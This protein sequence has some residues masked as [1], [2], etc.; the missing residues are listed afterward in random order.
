EKAYYLASVADSVFLPPEGIIE[1]NGLSSSQMFYLGLFEKLELQPEVFRVGTFKSAVEP[2]LRKDMS[3]ASKLQTATYLK[4]IWSVYS[5]DIAASRSIHIDQL[6]GIADE[7]I[8]GDGKKALKHGLIDEIA[9]ETDVFTKLKAA[10]N[11]AADDSQELTSF[12]KYM[13]VPGTYQSSRNRIA[14]VFTEGAIQSGKSTQGVIGSTTVVEQLRKARKDKKVKAVV[15]RVNSPG[16][17]AMA[18][19]MIAAELRLLKKEKPVIASFGDVAAS[20]GY[21]IAAPADKIFAQEN[22]ITGSIGIFGLW[23]NLGGALNNKLGLTFDGVE[24]HEHAN[25]GDPTFPMTPSEKAFMQSYVERGYGGFIEVVKNGRGFA[26]SV[27]VDKIAQGRVW[28]GQDAKEINL[29]DEFGNLGDAIEYAAEAAGLED[30]RI[31]RLQP[32]MNPFDEILQD[33]LEAKASQDPLYEEMKE[34][35]K[36][37]TMFPRNG[38]YALMPFD[39]NIE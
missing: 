15:L 22:T 18:S 11:K 4:D 2:Y 28:S 3:D 10:V 17:S 16:G 6:E 27:A 37:K 12:R 14:V 24:T 25:F 35:R 20:G 26:D 32:S 33:L 36:F 30:Y 34:L 31:Q 7:F 23:M 13:R 1:F 29:I 38:T 8:F 9:Y 19:D 5:R 21:Y 39:L